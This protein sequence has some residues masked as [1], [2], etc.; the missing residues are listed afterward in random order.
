MAQDET[1]QTKVYMEQGG[2]RYVVGSGGTMAVESGGSIHIADSGTLT[3][4]EGAA[5]SIVT[6]AS[7]GIAG[8]GFS[9]EE[10]TRLIVS[11]QLMLSVLPEA[12]DDVLAVSDLPKNVGTYMIAASATLISA[13]FWLP[14]VSAGREVYLGVAGDSTGTFTNVKTQVAVSTSGCII[15]GSLG[16]I[17]SNFT[18]NISATSDALVHLMAVSDNVWAIISQR[19]DVNEATIV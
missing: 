6:G 7:I 12:L 14:T 8:A 19:G 4:Q 3:L 1:Y 15:L 5:L 11:E 17:I 10:L 2:N 9:P 13:S 16:G 18:M